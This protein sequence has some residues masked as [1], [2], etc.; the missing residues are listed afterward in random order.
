MKALPQA[1]PLFE[2]RFWISTRAQD[3]DDI[4]EVAEDRL[5]SFDRLIGTVR[6]SGARIRLGSA[7][8]RFANVF[9]FGTEN[10]TSEA[11]NYS[12]Q[13]CFSHFVPKINRL[14][15]PLI[16]RLPLSRWD[17][18]LHLAYKDS[19]RARTYRPKERCYSARSLPQTEEK[20]AAPRIRP[21]VPRSFHRQATSNLALTQSV[22]TL[23]R[24]NSAV[25]GE[26]Q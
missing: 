11:K 14:I 24:S 18:R 7:R 1:H 3:C 22:F 8:H 5:A 2:K 15:A 4:F 26:S 6:A 16:A 23:S 21:S 10:P 13:G 12:L 9:Q 17:E 19:L 20:S 25:P